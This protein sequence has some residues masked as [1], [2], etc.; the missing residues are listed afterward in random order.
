MVRTSGRDAALRRDHPRVL[1]TIVLLISVVV[2]GLAGIRDPIL[3]RVAVLGACALVLWLSEIVPPY[4]TTLALLAAIPLVLGTGHPAYRIGAVLGWAADPVLALFF[5]GFTLSVAAS[6]HGLDVHIAERALAFSSHRRR[7]LLALVMAATA[8][9][10]MWIS[11]IAAAALML[12]ALR[13]HLHHGERTQSFRSALLLAVA[14]GANFGGMATPIGTGPNGIAIANLEPW[15]RITFLQW[16]GFALPL[17][18]GMLALAYFLIVGAHQ[19][20]GAYQSVDVRVEK[21]GRRARGL[22]VVFVLAVAAWLSEPLH[23]VSAPIVALC[24]AAVLFGGGWLKREDLGRIDWSTLLLIAGGIVLGRLAERSGLLETIARGTSGG[25]LPLML[26]ISSI[27]LVAA[28]MGAVIS[29]TASAAMLIPLALGFGFPRSIAVLIAIGTSLGVPFTISSPPNA[30]AYG[31]GGLSARD[32]LRVGLPLMLVGSL[33]VGLTGP[34][35]LRWM[36]LP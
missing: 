3:S 28:L 1:V 36:G 13:P 32:L 11:N 17:M 19:V 27:V 25:D 4:V 26:R 31:E 30:M 2:G 22:V 7:R 35:V 5:G 8:V 12:A 18:I 20:Q 16:M 14:M 23:D 6:R 34:L 10:S 24:V 9:L 21:L 33:V 15:V 29:N